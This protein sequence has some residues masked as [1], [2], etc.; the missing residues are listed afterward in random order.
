MRGRVTE[1]LRW[2]ARDDD[3]SLYAY[4][5]KPES[6][7]YTFAVESPAFFGTLNFNLFP[8]ITFENSPVDMEEEL[9]RMDKVQKE[10][11]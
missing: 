8:Q 1:G 2:L 11:E 7:G 6:N 3:G 9:N 5:K 10:R 4:N